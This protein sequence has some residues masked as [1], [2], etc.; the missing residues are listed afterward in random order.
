MMFGHVAHM[1]KKNYNLFILKIWTVQIELKYIL[2]SIK[3]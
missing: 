1:Y 2:K 3:W